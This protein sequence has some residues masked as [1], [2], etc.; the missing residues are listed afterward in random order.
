LHDALFVETSP[1]PVKYACSRLGFG[2]GFARL[3]MAPVTDATRKI[4]DDAMAHA[5]LVTA[6]AAE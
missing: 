2:D 5:G 4:V 1:G 6:K 3:P